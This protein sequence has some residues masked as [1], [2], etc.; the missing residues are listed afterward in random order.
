MI[1]IVPSPKKPWLTSHLGEWFVDHDQQRSN[2]FF[3]LTTPERGEKLLEFASQG[4]KSRLQTLLQLEVDLEYPKASKTKALHHALLHRRVECARHLV[5]K[6]ANVNARD[7]SGQTPLFVSASHGDRET[8]LFLLNEGAEPNI[9]DN[10]KRTPLMAACIGAHDG[11]DYTIL[12]DLVKQGAHIQEADIDG[13]RALHHAAQHGNYN[14]CARLLHLEIAPPHQPLATPPIFISSSPP[15]KASPK[16]TGT[17]PLPGYFAAVGPSASSPHPAPTTPS[18]QA[19]GVPEQCTALTLAAASGNV[20]LVDL[21]LKHEADAEAEMQDGATAMMVA[22]EKGH[23]EV[24]RHLQITRGYQK[25]NRMGRTALM[26]AAKEGQLG[27][28]QDIARTDPACVK[29][30]DKDGY[31][32]LMWAAST[33]HDKVAQTLADHGA[34]YVKMKDHKGETAADIARKMKHQ[35]LAEML[36]AKVAEANNPKKQ[37]VVTE[38]GKDKGSGWM[39]MLK[40]F[41]RPVEK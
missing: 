17:S 30:T 40:G 32:A 26:W 4:A 38:A 15:P 23:L 19:R 28:V 37:N 16:P 34:T 14:A 33:G 13:W 25:T 36:E 6:G 39:G 35:S 18:I 9:E 1:L 31:T 24:V 21:L 11:S 10:N 8:V 22:A 27:V 41:T 12:D 29:M 3:G 2:Q 20:R 7:D 5:N